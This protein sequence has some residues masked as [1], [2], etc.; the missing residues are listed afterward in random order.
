MGR[1]RNTPQM[2][3]QKKSPRKKLNKI[4][5]SNLPDRVQ[6]TGFK[7]AQGM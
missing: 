2:E 6:N 7:D 4:E 5:A 3:E 1:Q